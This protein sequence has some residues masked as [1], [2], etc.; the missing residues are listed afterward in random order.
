MTRIVLAVSVA[1]L[2]ALIGG[3]GDVEKY[4]DM[5]TPMTPTAQ[6]GQAPTSERDILEQL[7]INRQSYMESLQT[8][9]DYYAR[10]GNQM[11]LKLAR[12][13]LANVMASPQFNYVV[14]AEVAGAELRATASIPEADQLFEDAAT[15][16]KKAYLG[17]VVVDDKMLR[18]AMGKYSQLI[19]QYPAS[20]KIGEAAYRIGDAHEHFKEYSIAALYFERAAQ[21]DKNIQYPARFKA[22]YIYDRFLHDRQKALVLYQE[23]LA[24]EKGYRSY[25]EK[26]VL[27]LSK[28]E[29]PQ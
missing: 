10:T 26:R 4:A 2:V 28:K 22:A 1:A 23:S 5:R 11:Q 12:R 9:V 24:T 18:L 14:E 3:C 16:E 29:V 17:P 20:N 6:A 25:S 19:R 13:E 21:W 15:V 7:A 8:L 27:E